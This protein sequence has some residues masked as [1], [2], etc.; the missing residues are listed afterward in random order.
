MKHLDV[1]DGE[2]AAV[3]PEY[4]PGHCMVGE[5]IAILIL[6]LRLQDAETWSTYT[7]TLPVLLLETAIHRDYILSANGLVLRTPCECQ[8]REEH[9]SY[10][11]EKVLTQLDHEKIGY[12]DT[13]CIHIAQVYVSM[14]CSELTQYIAIL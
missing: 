9:I 4:R 14:S 13:A 10:L 6:Q 7:A 1:I 11:D 8:F 2:L 3:S 12:T 5:N